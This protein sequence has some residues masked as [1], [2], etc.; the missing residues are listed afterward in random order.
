M[1]TLCPYCLQWT[2]CT[3]TVW[4]VGRDIVLVRDLLPYVLIVARADG[5][6][7]ATLQDDPFRVAYP[8]FTPGV[9]ICN[10]IVAAW[11]QAW[12][13][14]LHRGPQPV[15]RGEWVAF[16]DGD[17]QVIGQV[18]TRPAWPMHCA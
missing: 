17:R 5:S 12:L 14:V 4:C 16:H 6:L 3:L 9:N 2:V 8:R 13:R 15:A 1:G 11:P 18:A 7:C 10:T